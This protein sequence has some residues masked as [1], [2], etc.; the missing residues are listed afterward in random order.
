MQALAQF[1]RSELRPP[2]YLALP[3]AGIDI[4]ASGIKVACL[5]ESPHGLELRSA[6]EV[7]LA[8]GV[9]SSGEIADRKAVVSAIESL[10]KKHR[11]TRANIALPEARGYLFEAL[12]PKGTKATQRTSIEQHLDEYVPLPSADVAFDFSPLA[13]EGES[14]RVVGVGYARRVVEE[15]VSAL[16]EA[17]V[18]V[19]AAESET[20]ALPRALF[21]NESEDTVLIVD[22]GKSTTKL[23]VATGRLPRFVTT[24][25][26]GGHALTLAIHKYFGATEEEAR[27]IKIER[28]IDPSAGNE[29]YLAAML[30][31]VSVIR[32]EIVRR[33]NYWQ[34]HAD[35][36]HT[37]IK[38]VL[39]VGGNASV[40]GLPEY[41]EDSLK[42]PVAVGDVFTNFAKNDTGHMPLDTTAALAY[43]TAIGLA[44]RDYDV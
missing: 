30:S 16:E 15:S 28:G 22:I 43:G 24:L 2:D 11:F 6:A 40:R 21:T 10:A 4:S 5:V 29:E 23:L 32:D 33:F 41:L 14:I 35:T 44:L 9:I 19:R 13:P 12:V 17:R 36:A 1:F 18:D 20:F 26:V 7:P 38:R 8:A 27:H 42:V 39:L 3:T 34:T 37:P 31:T 25:E